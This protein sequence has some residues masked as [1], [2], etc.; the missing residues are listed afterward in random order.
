MMIELSPKAM[1]RPFQD[2]LGY[3]FLAREF[4][5]GFNY[6]RRLEP[7]KF[8]FKISCQV[9]IVEQSS[10][11][12]STDPLKRLLRSFNMNRI[13]DGTAI[14]RLF[15]SFAEQPLRHM[16]IRFLQLFDQCRSA[17][18]MPPDRQLSAWDELA[19]PEQCA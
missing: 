15:P 16:K 8:S 13:P 2:Y 11:I 5:D 10:E 4:E 19:R 9:D 14:G 1:A 3:R 7:H 18:V 12:T 17:L 6:I